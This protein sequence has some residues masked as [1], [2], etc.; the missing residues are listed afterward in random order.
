[1]GPIK[2]LFLAALCVCMLSAQAGSAAPFDFK[3]LG[4]QLGNQDALIVADPHGNI[5]FSHNAKKALIPASTLKLLTALTAFHYLGRDYRFSTGFYLNTAGNLKI[6]GYGDPFLISEVIDEI[7]EILAKH[8]AGRLRA[9][10][11]ILVDHTYFNHPIIIPGVTD[12]SEPYDAPNG[13]LCVNYNTLNFEKAGGRFV[14]AEAQ[15]PLLPIALKRIQSSGL[16]RGRIR[17][18]LENDEI[19]TYAGQ[20]FKHFLQV[21]GMAVAGRVE[22]GR[23]HETDR[24]LLSYASP[25]TLEDVMMK[26]MAYSNNF[27]ANQVLLHTGAALFG[28]PGTL[29]KGVDA[30]HAYVRDELGDYHIRITEGSGISRQ[31]RVT[32]ESMLGILNKFKPY[33]HLLTKEEHDIFKTGTLKDVSTRAGY[34]QADDESLYPY[35]ILLNSPGKSASR[36]AGELQRSLI[37]GF[38]KA[39]KTSL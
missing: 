6:R 10:R 12:S 9:I 14:S 8:S 17:L 32:A 24:L 15:T 29:Q 11:N 18:S 35:V 27:I 39:P 1:M 36:V 13:A 19:F 37:G 22:M 28:A 31:N 21:H 30:A 20:L 5:L 38:K 25:F 2:T 7:A 23:V 3:N 4:S 16:D 33:H 34:I 26:M